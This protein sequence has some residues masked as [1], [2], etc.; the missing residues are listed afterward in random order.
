[1]AEATH[2]LMT[3]SLHCKSDI[4]LSKCRVTSNGFCAPGSVAR[5]AETTIAPCRHVLPSQAFGT[6]Q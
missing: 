6:S 1:M 4:T 3:C 2:V 5:T